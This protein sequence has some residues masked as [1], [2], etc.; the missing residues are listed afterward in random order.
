MKRS[1]NTI[2]WS[3]PGDEKI[4]DS[5]QK[6]CAEYRGWIQQIVIEDRLP[7]FGWMSPN[8]LVLTAE[9]FR[10]QFTVQETLND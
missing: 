10:S 3:H 9:A 5:Y 8:S 6:G 2:E 7:L 4:P 1:T